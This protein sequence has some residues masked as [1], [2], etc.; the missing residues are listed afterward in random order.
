MALGAW[1]T[2]PCQVFTEMKN[3]DVMDGVAALTLRSWATWGEERAP[4]AEGQGHTC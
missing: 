3:Q 4:A 1:R 2:F